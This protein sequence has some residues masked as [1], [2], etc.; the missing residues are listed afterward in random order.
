MPVFP[1][2]F[3]APSLW[4]LSLHFCRYAPFAVYNRRNLEGGGEGRDTPCAQHSK[5]KQSG[6]VPKSDSTSLYDLPQVSYKFYASIYASVKVRQFKILNKD[7][8][9]LH[10]FLFQS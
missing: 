9:K 7:T 4:T 2:G 8:G 6:F 5:S 1:K 3:T 10:L